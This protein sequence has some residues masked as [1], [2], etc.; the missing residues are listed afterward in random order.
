MRP[1]PEK[2]DALVRNA[3]AR[4]VDAAQLFSVIFMTFTVSK[5]KHREV[6]VELVCA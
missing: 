2:V 4:G 3:S 6:F 1:A 5:S